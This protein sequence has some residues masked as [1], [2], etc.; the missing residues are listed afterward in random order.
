MK[1]ILIHKNYTKICD[2]YIQLF[3][4]EM[5]PN[6]VM[7]VHQKETTHQKMYEFP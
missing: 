5:K 6:E 3:L 1:E 2:K 4:D 7:I